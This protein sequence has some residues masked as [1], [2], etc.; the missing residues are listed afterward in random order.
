MSISQM[1]FYILDILQSH[2]LVP[3]IKKLRNSLEKIAVKSLTTG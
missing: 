2:I 1:D 3:R